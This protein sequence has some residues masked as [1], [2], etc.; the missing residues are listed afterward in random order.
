MEGRRLCSG[1]NLQRFYAA[2]S[3]TNVNEGHITAPT[4]P[5]HP[6]LFYCAAALFHVQAMIMTSMAFA[7]AGNALRMSI[8]SESA[9]KEIKVTYRARSQLCQL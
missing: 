1:H 4:P 6:R 3:V 2:E 9:D 5:P 8:T 7:A